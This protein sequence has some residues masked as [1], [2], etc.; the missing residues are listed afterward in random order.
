FGL[1]QPAEESVKVEEDSNS[2]STTFADLLNAWLAVIPKND[3]AKGVLRR[4]KQVDK[5]LGGQMPRRQALE[6]ITRY[7][8]RVKLLVSEK[9]IVELWCAAHCNID[10]E[11]LGEFNLPS[12]TPSEET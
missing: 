11:W 10:R 12:E 1:V 9:Q 4:P 2:E 6:D 7:A 8:I 5:W 3:L